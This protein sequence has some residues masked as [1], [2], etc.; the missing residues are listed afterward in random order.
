MKPNRDIKKKYLPLEENSAERLIE[1]S[2]LCDRLEPFLSFICIVHRQVGHFDRKM[3]S[4]GLK[5]TS[6]CPSRRWITKSAN[7]KKEQNLFCLLNHQI[8]NILAY[9]Y[10]EMA[11]CVFIM[12]G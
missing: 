8:G 7:D 3:G 10:F 11:V 2:Q 1:T 4:C 5:E 9:S 6:V 12:F